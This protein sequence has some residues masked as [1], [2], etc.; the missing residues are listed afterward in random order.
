MNAKQKIEGLTRSWY[1]YSLVAAVLSVL[2]LRASGVLSLAIGLGISIVL[3][4]IGLLISVAVVTFLGRKLVHR[5]SATRTFLVVFSAIFFVL[6]A[7]ATVTAGWDFLTTWSLATLCNV[8]LMASCTLL[9]G[10]SFRVL[11]ETSVKAY[12][13]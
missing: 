1:G 12:F 2:S 3:N 4:A 9:N 6:G 10:R 13:V 7:I 8:V 5:S 11:T